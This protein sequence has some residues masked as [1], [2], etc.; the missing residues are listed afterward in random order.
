VSLEKRVAELEAIVASTLVIM[1][2]YREAANIDKALE[3]VRFALEPATV[4]VVDDEGN[5]GTADL[6]EEAG[7]R[8][9]RVEVLR[10]PAKSGL[11]SAYKEGFTWGLERGYEVLVGMDADLS[12]DAK[13][14][15]RMLE[16]LVDGAD[17]AIGSRY[18][19]GGSV[20]NWPLRRRAISRWGN[21]YASRVLR[22][23]ISDLTSA[24]RAYRAE[25]LRAVDLNLLRAQGYGFL[26]ELVHTLERSGATVGEVPITFVNRYAGR[27]KMSAKIALESLWLVTAMAF[28][29][30]PATA[31]PAGRRLAIPEGRGG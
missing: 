5:D 4:V 12:H 26:I 23:R 22:T 29:G 16:A 27:S 13:V 15:P 10:R 17:V 2:T 24:F 19:R 11:A 6:A 9:G 1:P 31:L 21:W 8:L 14:L 20:V 3:A 28:S 7:R 30:P 18:V 25:A